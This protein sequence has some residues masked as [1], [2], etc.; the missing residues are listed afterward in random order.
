MKKIVLILMVFSSFMFASSN[1][2]TL[3]DK[4]ARTKE[5]IKKALEDEEKFARERRFYDSNS[6]D[7]KGSEVNEDSLKDLKKIK[8]M[9]DF[10]MNNVYD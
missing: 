8:P 10:D 1:E 9:Y 7:F 3:S 5:A 4:E 6:Y 2:T